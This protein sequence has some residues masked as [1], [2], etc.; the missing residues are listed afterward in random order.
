M[1][2][3]YVPLHDEGTEVWRPVLARELAPAVFEIPAETKVP[4]E[5][6]WAF[7]PGDH[8]RC[9]L[10]RLSGSS[11]LVAVELVAHAG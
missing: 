4:P 11:V 8:V 5:E 6:T 7:R 10:R 2:W 1:T 9:A 3:I